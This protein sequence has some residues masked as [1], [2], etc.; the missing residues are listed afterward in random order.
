MKTNL[1]K[2]F[3]KFEIEK[4]ELNKIVGGA[5]T[6]EQLIAAVWGLTPDGGSSTW[7]SDGKGCFDGVITH[8]AR[9]DNINVI[10]EGKL[11]EY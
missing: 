10:T 11:C 5:A 3:T 6:T 7:T 8:P 9:Y 4:T 2:D 1:I